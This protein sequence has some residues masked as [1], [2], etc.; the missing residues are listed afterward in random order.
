M[1]EPAGD[2]LADFALSFTK[3]RERKEAFLRAW[4]TG[5]GW[6]AACRAAGVAE[7][8]PCGWSESDRVF[9]AARARAEAA[10]AEGHEATLDQLAAGTLPGSQVQL[11]AIALRLRGLKPGR[12]RDSAQRVEVSGALRV[13]DGN[14]SRA[15]EML[16]RFAAAAR[17]RAAA[18]E[19]P[20]AL[21]EPEADDA[22][23]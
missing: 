10:I 2:W 21:P 11:N 19:I 5:V 15:V 9:A 1:D 3:S 4:V 16:E 22:Q 17:L 14:A 12:Y 20:A 18:A 13:E 6:G 7:A 23:G 8:T